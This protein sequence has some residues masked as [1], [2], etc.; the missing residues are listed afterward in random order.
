MQE[1]LGTY[2][3][4]LFLGNIQ[5]GTYSKKHTARNIQQEIQ[6]K[7]FI[8][9]NIQQETYSNDLIRH[10]R[11]MLFEK[12]VGWFGIHLGWWLPGR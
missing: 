3:K 7:K 4:E 1:L 12:G 6:S 11:E 10:A 8:A 9:R 5:Q 2:R